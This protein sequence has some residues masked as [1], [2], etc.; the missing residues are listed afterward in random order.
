V[1]EY[2]GGVVRVNPVTKAASL[3]L[4]SETRSLLLS[5]E[6]GIPWTVNGVQYPSSVIRFPKNSVVTIEAPVIVES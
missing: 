5:C 6:L 3:T 1:T 2:S 4:V